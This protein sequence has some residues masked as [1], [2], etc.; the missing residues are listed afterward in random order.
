MATKP[1]ERILDWASGGTVTDP[2]AGKEATGWVIDDRPPANWWNWIL[3][4]FGN[5]LR[6]FE[7]TGTPRA[8]V[9]VATDGTPTLTWHGVIGPTITS[10]TYSGFDAQINFSSPIVAV[11]EEAAV[12]VTGTG[13]TSGSGIMTTTS[14]CTV[15]LWSVI[16]G[17]QL[18]LNTVEYVLQVV[19]YGEAP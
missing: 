19:I 9:R 3:S 8:V 10:V 13:A 4:S 12:Q 15:E 5:W 14:Q 17:T 18:A 16:S 1:T 2:G 11:K 7:S 6:W